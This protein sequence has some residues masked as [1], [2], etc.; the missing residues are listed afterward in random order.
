MKPPQLKVPF[1]QPYIAGNEM[2]NIASAI[3]SGQL[4][5]DG[6]FTAGCTYIPS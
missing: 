5:G 4:A 2:S 6:P 1:N 3:G